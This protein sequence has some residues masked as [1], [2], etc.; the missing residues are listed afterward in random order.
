MGGCGGDGESPAKPDDSRDGR[1]TVVTDASF[2]DVVLEAGGPAVVFFTAPW[3]GPDRV[4]APSVDEIAA[5]RED[6]R[7]VKLDVDANPR[8]A[9]RYEILSIPTLLMFR[10][11]KVAGRIVGAAPKKR[12]ADQID[13]A[14]R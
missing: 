4:I 7:I 8:T 2:Q 1:V 3:S 10:D 13:A 6:I 9:G 11:G 12:I 5:E 14:F